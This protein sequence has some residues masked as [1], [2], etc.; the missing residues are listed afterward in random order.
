M[1]TPRFIV[2][3]MS[4]ITHFLYFLLMTAKHSH[5]SSKILKC[6]WNISFSSFRKCYGLLDSEL[7]LAGCQPLKIKVHLNILPKLWLLVCCHHLKIQR[8]SHFWNFNNCNSWSKHDNYIN[9]P[10]FSYTLWPLSV[11]IF[12]F[13]ISTPSKFSSMR[14]PIYIMWYLQAC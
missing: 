7:P 8:L 1:F 2:I 10:F 12:H 11:G 5:S 4:K 13:R 9:G 3:K 14:S 6:I